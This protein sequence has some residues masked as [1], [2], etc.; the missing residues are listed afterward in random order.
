MS[1]SG[2]RIEGRVE[3]LLS[4]ME[5]V[6]R[7]D[8]AELEAIEA[9]EWEEL[10]AILEAQKDLWRELVP[11]VRDGNGADG[12]E[13]RE[14]LIALYQMRRRNHARIE[15]V[16]VQMRRRLVSAHAA[17]DGSAR[18]REASRAA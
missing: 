9:G 1:G 7:L 2:A 5:R 4:P 16:L 15:A 18:Y 8:R 13:A 6:E 14:A 11:M 3:D 17:A 10:D 12:D